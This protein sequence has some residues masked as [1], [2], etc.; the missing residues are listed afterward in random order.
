MYL[1][2]NK[3]SVEFLWRKKRDGRGL[4]T[5]IWPMIS[6]IVTPWARVAG[7]LRPAM[8]TATTLNSIF[9]PAGRPFTLYWF[10][11]TGSSLACTH[12]SPE[13]W[14]GSEEEAGVRRRSENQ[15][16]SQHNVEKFIRNQ[17]G[18]LLNNWPFAK[19]IPCIAVVDLSL[20]I[21]DIF[22]CK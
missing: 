9:S 19:H 16:Q 13:G 20:E 21:P 15:N 4:N 18:I 22:I 10:F 6:L 2:I 5:H 1:Y 12:W 11:D 14:D 17:V 3:I 8:L 7:G